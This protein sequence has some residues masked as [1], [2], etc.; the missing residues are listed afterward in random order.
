M[1]WR[2]VLGKKC[3]GLKKDSSVGGVGDVT[4]VPNNSC[5]QWRLNIYTA[6]VAMLHLLTVVIRMGTWNEA[7]TTFNPATKI[8]LNSTFA[9]SQHSRRSLVVSW[10]TKRLREANPGWYSGCNWIHWFN[11]IVLKWVKS[12]VCA[13]IRILKVTSDKLSPDQRIPP[14]AGSSA[15]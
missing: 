15:I 9:T 6:S 7:S 5:L 14:M 8:L 2:K 13:F 10:K 3:S 11:Q 1:V 12:F 4:R